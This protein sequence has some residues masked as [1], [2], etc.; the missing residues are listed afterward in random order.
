MAP[1]QGAHRSDLDDIPLFSLPL[2]RLSPCS[3]SRRGRADRAGASNI[4]P[5][6][7]RVAEFRAFR[8][9]S[10]GKL[11]LM[12]L[13]ASDERPARTSGASS[14]CEGLLVEL[15]SRVDVWPNV[16]QLRS[17]SQT[18]VAESGANPGTRIGTDRPRRPSPAKTWPKS[19]RVGRFRLNCQVWSKFDRHHQIFSKTASTLAETGPSS[20]EIAQILT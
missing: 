2:W 8:T 17:E 10:R 3:R 1:K 12:R 7:R 4:A 18:C 14:H 13:R 11:R 5:G 15:N 16:G 20:A 9:L 6:S 19:G